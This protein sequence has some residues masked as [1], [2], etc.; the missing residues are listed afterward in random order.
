MR[1]LLAMVPL[2]V[3]TVAAAQPLGKDAP[4]PRPSAA[5][6]L[7]DELFSRRAIRRARLL[8]QMRML[9][10]RDER[11]ECVREAILRR[12]PPEL[13]PT[14]SLAPNVKQSGAVRAKNPRG[15][16]PLESEDCGWDSMQPGH[17]KR[18]D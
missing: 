9:Q 13:R 12:L 16:L 6:T 17:Q 2:V 3:F 1:L 10:L 15:A 5:T 7:P 14:G 4:S 18:A 11:L 8:I